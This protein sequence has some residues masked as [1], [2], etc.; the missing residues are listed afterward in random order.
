M[1]SS[2]L[3]DRTVFVLTAD[4]YIDHVDNE[5][6][7]TVASGDTVTFSTETQGGECLLTATVGQGLAPAGFEMMTD[8]EG[9]KIV[10]AHRKGQ[11]V[12]LHLDD[13]EIF[14][15]QAVTNEDGCRVATRQER[16]HGRGATSVVDRL[17]GVLRVGGGRRE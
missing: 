5:V 17:L 7:V 1:R 16:E 3:P 11:V 4:R 15:V 12:S 13:G 2:N 14:H 10:R 9:R 8:T 6:R